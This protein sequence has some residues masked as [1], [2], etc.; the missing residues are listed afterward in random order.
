MSMKHLIA[1]HTQGPWIADSN[2]VFRDHGIQPHICKMA[3]FFDYEQ[4]AI[5]ARLIAA[6]PDLLEALQACM[7]ILDAWK[8]NMSAE[9]SELLAITAA[10]LAIHKAI[11]QP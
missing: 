2:I 6:A 10:E 11:A 5:N 3:T 9:K 1:K 4:A 8:D 7:P